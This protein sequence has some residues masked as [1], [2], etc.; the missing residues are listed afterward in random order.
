M[1]T[2]LILLQ[3]PPLVTPLPYLYKPEFPRRPPNFNTYN[4]PTK[5]AQYTTM[6][7]KI[8]I[9]LCEHHDKNPQLSQKDLNQWLEQKHKM[10]VSQPTISGLL[11]RKATILA[12][13]DH[14]NLDAKC[15]RNVKYPQMESAL[16]E[17]FLS[18]QDRFNVSG[19]LIE[20]K[21]P[22][23]L[24]I[25]TLS[26]M[27]SRSVDGWLESS[28]DRHGIKSFRRFVE[29]GSVEI[30]LIEESLPDIRETLDKYEWKD[31]YNMDK[32]RLFYRL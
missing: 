19:G 9:A 10:K 21:Q 1:S 11:K 14:S 7:D 5:G 13:A 2:F 30:T 3:P 29:S 24:I 22:F 6:T 31:I 4:T 16:V 27:C 26:M 28:K 12:K 8:R 32:T 25:S 17:W 20:A 18:H 15:Q 23:L